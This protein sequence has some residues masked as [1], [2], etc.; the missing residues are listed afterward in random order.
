M[1]SIINKIIYGAIGLT[2][3]FLLMSTIVLPHFNTTYNYTVTGLSSATTQGLFLLV[4][5]LALIGFSI[6]YLPRTRR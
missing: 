5:V 3:L 4:L 6:E 1:T 2:V